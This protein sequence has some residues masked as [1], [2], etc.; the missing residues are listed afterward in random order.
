MKLSDH[1]DKL[2][3]F[4]VIV[5][6]G[7]MREAA[8]RLH[9]TQPSL[10]KLIQNLELAS[11]VT[12]LSRGRMGVAVTE[13]GKHLLEYATLTLKGL[14]DVEQKLLNPGDGMAGHLRIGAYASLAEYLWPDFIPALKKK[15]PGLR[16]SI[17][18]SEG[19]S[20]LQG[21]ARGEIDILVDAEPRL[22]DGFL[23]WNLYEDR[24]N[25]YLSTAKAEKWSAQSID[26][27]PLIYSPNAFDHENRKILQHLEGNGY[28]FPEKLEFDSFMAVLAFAR[29]GVG[30]AVLPNRLAETAVK[31]GQLRAVSLKKFPPKGFGSHHFAATIR[32]S[33]KDDPRVRV[34][35]KL[36]RQ[37][38]E[39][40]GN[41]AQSSR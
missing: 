32:E 8:K 21:L 12:L 3:A 39:E 31:A 22:T 10:T 13:S 35:I 25:F 1:L 24:F 41:A 27:T 37:W 36:L 28:H 33:R 19:S 23:S 26:T 5:E 7:T 4:K 6:A 9:V 38:V 18:T 20:H 15:A 34:V 11:G 29:K 30:L 16:L 2:R 17:F 14:E 40:R